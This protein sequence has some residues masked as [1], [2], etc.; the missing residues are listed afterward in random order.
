MM[1]SL[2]NPSSYVAIFISFNL[3]EMDYSEEGWI[4]FYCEDIAERWVE[5]RFLLFC[6]KNKKKQKNKGR[7]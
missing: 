5:I 4:V 3:L 2:S 1:E 6:S 7:I